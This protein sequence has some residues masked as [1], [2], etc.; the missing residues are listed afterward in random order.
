MVRASPVVVY[1]V[2]RQE[3]TYSF[4]RSVYADQTHFQVLYGMM[5]GLPSCIYALL[6]SVICKRSSCIN[7]P[8]HPAIPKRTPY[9]T[10]NAVLQPSSKP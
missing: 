5:L 2:V 4:H 6:R 10:E 3:F 8:D 7:Q 9:R 1:T